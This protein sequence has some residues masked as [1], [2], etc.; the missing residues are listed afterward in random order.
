MLRKSF[1]LM[2]LGVVAV[3]PQTTPRT[4]SIR[5]TVLDP[6]GAVVPDATVTVAGHHKT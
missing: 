2:V 3:L 6:S 1:V 4:Q 5:G